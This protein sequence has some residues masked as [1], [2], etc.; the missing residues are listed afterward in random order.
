VINGDL[1]W[2]TGTTGLLPSVR[3]T[4]NTRVQLSATQN[5]MGLGQTDNVYNVQ[6]KT[7][8]GNVL[9]DW[10]PYYYPFATQWLN[11]SLD[12]SE[13]NEIDFGIKVTKFPAHLGTSFMG[14][15]TLGSQ[16]AT[17]LTCE[18]HTNLNTSPVDWIGGDLNS[19]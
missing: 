13:T 14:T 10:S 18:G 16:A 12:L 8:V 5:D 19:D 4:G 11:E 17:A 6:Y 3:N 7:R 15:L 2:N 9:T 1:P